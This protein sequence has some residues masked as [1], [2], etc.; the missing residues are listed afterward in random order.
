MYN[1]KNE[2]EQTGYERDYE[3]NPEYES[4]YEME[5][6]ENEFE[7][8]ENV[9]AEFEMENDYEMENNYQMEDENWQ[10]EVRVRDHRTGIPGASSL[11][12]RNF[13]NRRPPS[14]RT[15]NYYRRPG[16]YTNYRP[17]SRSY[18]NRPPIRQVYYNRHPIFYNRYRPWR[19]GY[20]SPYYNAYNNYTGQFSQYAQDNS[21]TQPPTTGSSPD[22][23]LQTIQ[24]LTQ[25]MASTN[26][27]VEALQQSLSNANNTGNA[28]PPPTGT[29]NSP[30]SD[31]PSSE[32]EMQ[33]H[34]YNYE[35]DMENEEINNEVN[36]EMETE[37]AM[38][39]LSTNTEMELDN[40]LGGFLGGGLKN[41]VKAVIKKALPV[42][43]TA[44]GSFLGGPLGA[45]IGN[46]IGSA[47]S[48]LFEL[49]LEGLSNED[50][51]FEVAKAI[52]RLATDAA[53]GLE[54]NNKTGDSRED[55][56]NALIQS[57][58]SNAP[59]LITR[60][61]NSFNNNAYARR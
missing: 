40:F 9:N 26:A 41:L 5:T 55:A 50:K 20:S 47:A 3:F 14:Y 43:G 39:L 38:E 23:I 16:G 7:N 31:Q 2:Y 36:D 35:Y 45:G 28:A 18:I 13:I 54:E 33:D 6:P 11:T 24:N 37:M 30:G 10:N 8:E 1:Y 49:E 27:N 17:Q 25:Q 52:I 57:A 22:Y 58:I 21:N 42:A 32:F 29:N 15:G 51:E 44:A 59:G 34:E 4:A 48:N 12:S 60:K 56:R 61:R 53:R 46:K 19:Y